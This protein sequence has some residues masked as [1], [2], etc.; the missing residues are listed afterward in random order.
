MSLTKILKEEDGYEIRRIAKG[1]SLEEC[2][3]CTTG[4]DLDELHKEDQRFIRMN[5]ARGRAEGK[6]EA[7]DNFFEKMRTSP[8]G[9]TL[10]AQYLATF[11]DDWP[12][13]GI[14]TTQQGMSFKILL[15]G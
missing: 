9:G 10:A 8:N 13:D 2:S 7:V 3:V 11:A 6:V 15:D 1:V 14:A 12:A 4:L 5:H